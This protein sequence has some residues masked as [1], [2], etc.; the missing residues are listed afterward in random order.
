M[1]PGETLKE[2]SGTGD[3]A[4]HGLRDVDSTDVENPQEICAQ[5]D[6]EDCFVGET[7]KN[8]VSCELQQSPDLVPAEFHI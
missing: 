7:N 3:C 4:S 1:K 2:Q 6:E 5:V 8:D